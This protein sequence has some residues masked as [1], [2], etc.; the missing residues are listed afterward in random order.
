MTDR[1][2]ALVVSLDKDYR[3][4][5]I[6]C[7]IDAVMMLKGVKSV[8]VNVSSIDSIVAESRYK[9]SVAEKLINMAREINS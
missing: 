9:Q 7:L 8:D 3:D 4:D 2:N 1:V 6:Q 5:D